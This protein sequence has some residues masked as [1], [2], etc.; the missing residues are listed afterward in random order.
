[1]R[2][3]TILFVLLL[4]LS[5]GQSSITIAQP[6]NLPLIQ[7]QDLVYQGAFRIPGQTYGASSAN[8]MPGP[9]AYNP[10]N[11]SLFVTGFDLD[12]AIAEFGIPPLSTSNDAS[13]LNPA[14]NLQNFR[15]ILNATPDNNPQG[16]DEI[17]GMEIIGNRLIVNAVE[18]Y[19][20][21]ANN[22]HTTLVV[23]NP[24]N[25]ASS[26]IKGYYSLQGAAHA[27]GWI[28]P[29]PV[30]WQSV[31]GSPYLAGSSSK[32]SI[33]G[34]LAVGVS[35]FGFDPTVFNNP[36][37]GQIPTTTFL[38]YD[39]ADP[40]YADYSNYQNPR[41]NLISVNG[42]TGPGHTFAD[43]QATVGSNDLW[44][45]ISQAS[46]GMIIPGTRTYFSIGSSGGHQSGIGYK[47]TQN[48]GN[49][50]GGPCP[51]DASDVYNYYWLWDVNDLV[52]V[53]NGSM[54][55]ADVRPYNHGV[56]NAPLQVDYD[57]QTPELHPVMGGTYD[58]V[59]EI[60]YLS[61]Y[62]A[63]S[64]GTYDRVPAIVAYKMAATPFVNLELTVLQ[65]ATYDPSTDAM[66]SQLET[67]GLLPTNQTF[68]QPPWNYQGTETKSLNAISDWVLVSFRTGV[69][70]S[71][72]I[73]RAAGLL[74]ID[75]RIYFTNSEVLP[76]NVNTPV[77]VVIETRNHLTVMSPTPVNIVNQSLTFDFTQT[78]SYSNPGAL[79]QKQLT[80]G[81]WV[82]FAGDINND[83]DINGADKADWAIV[84]GTF[85][86][87]LKADI[88]QD[89][90]VNGDDRIDWSLNNGV[91]S[92]VPK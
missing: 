42:S 1:M 62:D 38:D 61:L 70:P 78:D 26:P 40:L 90:D 71:T 87:Y 43:A 86:S 28:T 3:T 4:I 36:P 7:I 9:I 89:G 58:P 35:A 63:G 32:F 84:N 77:Y 60:L 24:S 5:L 2:H 17:S 73:A 72:E 12:G 33:I 25:L 54:N 34:R 88:N 19:D 37:S 83:Q 18:W 75:G 68:N 65:E 64:T 30:E 46:F 51:Y 85:N 13:Q 14:P 59:S 15:A 10:A 27:A 57:T 39:L 52:A 50:C 66:T 31:L 48:N 53:K 44:T 20:A 56:F 82:M 11:N 21:P 69:D 45:G 23:E 76:A 67:L 81:K 91:F 79:G 49:L 22:T 92:D 16:I 74:Q 6:S 55:P 8:Y 29:I 80:N 47:P 41:Y